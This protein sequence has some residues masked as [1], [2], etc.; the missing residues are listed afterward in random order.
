MAVHD[1]AQ[2][3]DSTVGDAEVREFV[4]VHDSA[5]GDDSRLY[6]R[7]SVKKSTVG[8]SVDVN[9]GAYVEN[10]RLGDRVQVGP[11]AVVAGVTHELTG[12]GM[13]HREDVFERVVVEAGA[14]VGAGAVVLPGTTVGEDAVVA[15]NATV[16]QDVPAGTLVRPAAESVREPLDGR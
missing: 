8:A 9:A 6:E 3:V 15:A 7:V 14:F 11:N 5:I 2:F 1:T 16:E 13:T 10:A 12:R 4:T